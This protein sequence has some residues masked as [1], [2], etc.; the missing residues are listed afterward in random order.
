MLICG[1]NFTDEVIQKI[2]V[3]VE[4]EPTISRRALS[5]RVCEWLDWRTPNGK[6]KEMSCRVALLRLHRQGIVKLP[7]CNVNGLSAPKGGKKDPPI[8]QIEPV[9]CNLKDLGGVEL[10]RVGSRESK[11]SRVWNA[12]MDRYHYL[13][14][15]PLCG[16]QMRYLIKS[17]YGWLGGLAFSGAAWR[18][19]ARDG[20]IGWG[21]WARKENLS[22]VVCNS[23]FLILPQVKVSNLASHVL[24]L[25]V[26]QLPQ[27]WLERY[28]FEPVLLETF[29]ERDRFQGT[30]YRA[31][32][33]QYV[34]T[35][36]G[37][38]RQ[39]RDH[40]HSV[41][42]KDVY[43]FPMRKDARRVLCCEPLQ[44][45][46]RCEPEQ[47]VEA[48]DWAEDEFGEADLGDRRLTKRLVGI[49]RDFYARPQA[50]VPQACQTRAKTKAAYRFFDH[51]KMGMDKVLE[52]HYEA[53]LARVGQGP[54]VLAVQDTT[55]LNYSTHPA[56]ENL[57]PIGS[58][59]DGIIGLL[60]HDTMAFNPDGT[61]L[62]LL[63]VQCWARDPE[64]FGKK[65]RRH[66]LPIEQKES[67]RWLISFR[68]VAE[69][70]RRSPKTT[71]VS[72][73]DREADIYELFELALRQPSAPKLLVRAS[74]N[75]LLAEGQGH[76]W[77]KVSEQ[78]ISGIQEVLVPRRGNRPA[79][80]ARLEVRF[81]EITLKPPKRKPR[82]RELTIWAV[83]AQE[84]EAPQDVEPIEWMLLTTCQV[85]TFDEAIEKL[86]WYAVRWGI[87]VYHRTLKSGCKIEERQ[88]GHADRIETCLAIDLVVAWRIF[89]LTKLGR[90][91]P[92]VPCTVF[93][94]ES[95]WKS[96]T[97]YITQNPIPPDRPPTL[98]EA[99]RMVASL[100]GFLGRNSDGEP[101]T[102]SL[103]LGLQR[104]D[105]ITT[106]W[107]VMTNLH[108]PYPQEPP[109]SSNPGYG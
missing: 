7:E 78:E 76:L 39:D 69:A 64:D 100:G 93:F 104:L 68:K 94:E 71:F 109:V 83:L 97:A 49:V 105:D 73:G 12:L 2:R 11:A 32:N 41:P 3:T 86:A 98:R 1:Q 56:T 22:K 46:V 21:D 59:P 17:P 58:C 45:V 34:G 19:E 27:D 16:A 60:L 54:V 88:L 42:I 63:D 50:S 84:V 20:W 82:F 18:V 26:R 102:K 8:V 40:T 55:S 30:C 99:I 108:V 95:E 51:P 72:V 61:P 23:R 13:G 62:G 25:C 33:W 52:Q 47:G 91:T 5:L 70:Q 15:G 36:C 9:R 67:N 37:R 79:R 44:G 90:E 66:E 107:K 96:L 6:P 75:R 10:I 4:S 53:T 38:G 103:W 77:E 89:H 57:G 106:M 92:D 85:T 87:E 28:G 14:A 48:Q 81:A 24:S 65:T 31:A 101:G 74:H 35:T 80:V 43:V 29:V